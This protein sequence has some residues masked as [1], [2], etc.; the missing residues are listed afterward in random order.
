MASHRPLRP[1]AV[2][3]TWPRA[4]T[5]FGPYAR[6]H[7][8][9]SPQKFVG[10]YATVKRRVSPVGPPVAPLSRPTAVLC[11]GGRRGHGKIRKRRVTAAAR[12]TG[13]AAVNTEE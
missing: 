13:D 6:G 1:P 9:N 7:S 4:G 3:L 2:L 12:E 11:N 5:P 8:R 10:S